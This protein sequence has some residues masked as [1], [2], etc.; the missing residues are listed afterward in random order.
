MYLDEKY[1]DK[2]HNICCDTTGDRTHKNITRTL[3][4][5]GFAFIFQTQ[6]YG[7]LQLVLIDQPIK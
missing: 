7:I 4:D 6:G 2:F 1:K 5:N 3:I